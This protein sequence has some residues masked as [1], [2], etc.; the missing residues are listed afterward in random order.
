MSQIV[1]ETF[2]QKAE[3]EKEQKEEK[4][5]QDKIEHALRNVKNAKKSMFAP[6]F[7]QT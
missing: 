5:R 4:V 3:R 6:K 2:Q 1:E 7:M